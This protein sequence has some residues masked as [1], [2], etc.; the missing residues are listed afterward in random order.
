MENKGEFV[1]DA[2]GYGD[3][4]E[5]LDDLDSG[6]VHE[7]EGPLVVGLREAMPG[8]ESKGWDISGWCFND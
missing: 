6:C 3:V 2:V 8:G 5:F 4:R 1:A 7:V